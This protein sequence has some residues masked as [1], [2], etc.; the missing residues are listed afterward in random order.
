MARVDSSDT[1]PTVN[2][3]VGNNDR[4]AI[5]DPDGLDK[6]FLDTEETPGATVLFDTN[7]IQIG[8]IHRGSPSFSLLTKEG[9]DDRSSFPY[10][11]LDFKRIGYFLHIGKTHAGPKSPWHGFLPKP[12][13]S[14]P[15]WPSVHPGSPDHGR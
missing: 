12:W 8:T 11:C 4:F 6:A 13:T 14:L 15:A 1:F 2:A 5:P 3:A 9:H 10:L 7:G